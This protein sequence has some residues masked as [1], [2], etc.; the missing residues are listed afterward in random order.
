MQA[1]TVRFDEEYRSIVAGN[2]EAIAQEILDTEAELKNLEEQRN[3]ANAQ[4]ISAEA[5]M[6]KADSLDYN[7]GQGKG[8]SSSIQRTDYDSEKADIFSVID[9][10]I[11]K[12]KLEIETLQNEI[13][14]AEESNDWERVH[15]LQGSLNE[16]LDILIKFYQ[17]K[18]DLV[19]KDIEDNRKL[20]ENLGGD[21]NIINEDGT[22]NDAI[23]KQIYE[24][25]NQE[26]AAAAAAYDNAKN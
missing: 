19:Q 4:I 3:K 15:S 12:T 23:Y 17:E 13:K 9:G 22:I 1:D 21:N 5:M 6:A 18:R 7:L 11:K 26:I 2:E 16:Q 24:R 25:K 20:I 8:K 14:Q 10:Q